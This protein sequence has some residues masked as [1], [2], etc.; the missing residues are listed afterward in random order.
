[1]EPSH[2]FNKKS[3]A[4]LDVL[5]PTVEFLVLPS[6]R[7]GDYCVIRGS[8]P[9]GVSVPLHSHP[10]N[11]TF[12]SAVRQCLSSGAA[13]ECFQVDKYERGR[14]PPRGLRGKA[15]LEERIG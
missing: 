12:F 15:R 7:A 2:G 1:M 13:K 5:G 10:D 8:I 14:F 3:H 6:E 4:V 9:P 11:E